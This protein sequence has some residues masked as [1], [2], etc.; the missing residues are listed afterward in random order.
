MS[1]FLID[2]GDWCGGR[3]FDM[4]AGGKQVFDEYQTK[5][6]PDC[7]AGVSNLSTAAG[8]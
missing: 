5:I 7:S 8:F 4:Q 2:L 6:F 1:E 3:F